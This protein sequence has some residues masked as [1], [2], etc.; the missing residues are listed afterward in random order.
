MARAGRGTGVAQAEPVDAVGRGVEGE[1]RVLVISPAAV[2][3]LVGEGED[4]HPVRRE[5]AARRVDFDLVREATVGLVRR[6]GAEVADPLAL[7]ADE[8]AVVVRP[9]REGRDAHQL[10]LHEQVVVDAEFVPRFEP[11]AGVVRVVVAEGRV[12]L[13]RAAEGRAGHRLAVGV[14]QFEDRV[15]R[16]PEPR[17][18]HLGHEPLALFRPERHDVRGPRR[19]QLAIGR[20]RHRRQCRRGVGERRTRELADDDRRGTDGVAG[21]PLDRHGVPA[22]DGGVGLHGDRL[23]GERPEVDAADGHAGRDAARDAEREDFG[24]HRDR[25][26]VQAVRQPGVAAELAV[27]DADGVAA[28][29]EEFEAEQVAFA[30]DQHA[31]GGVGQRQHGRERGRVGGRHELHAEFVPGRP[32]EAVSV[33]VAGPVEAAGDRRGQ[34]N[35][36]A[37]LALGHGGEAVHGELGRAPGRQGRVADRRGR[38]DGEFGRAADRAVVGRRRQ[39]QCQAVVGGRGGQ[40]V[41]AGAGEGDRRR[42]APAGGVRGDGGHGRRLR[43]GHLAGR[44]VDPQDGS[45]EEAQ[46]ELR[47]VGRQRG[48]RDCVGLRGED[49]DLA[50][51]RGGP[52]LQRPVFADR[53]QHRPL[54]PDEDARHRRLVREHRRRQLAALGGHGP[55]AQAAV[56][57]GGVE[58]LA[59]RLPGDRVNP[60]G[61]VGQGVQPLIR[62]RIPEL[63]GAVGPGAGEQ[64]AVGAVSERVHGVRVVG[65]RR[66]RLARGGQRHGPEFDEPVVPGRGQ[67]LAVR[68]EVDRVNRVL[69]GG[70]RHRVGVVR[71][72]V[73]AQ[74][75]GLAGCPAGHGERPARGERQ[76]RHPA[77][78]PGERAGRVAGGGVGQRHPVAG[79]GGEQFAVGP[80]REG[81]DRRG[82]GR[83][84]RES[85]GEQEDAE[86]GGGPRGEG[87]VLILRSGRR[88]GYRQALPECSARTRLRG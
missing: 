52:R 15:Q 10:A 53:V 32:G 27:A 62:R 82:G 21:G 50:Q 3:V 81:G 48:G 20:E 51:G 77:V 36:L 65:Q 25:A 66:R 44:G 83:H 87:V 30:L 2:V 26:E 34:G 67:G 85:G 35:R 59:V 79:A 75:A 73:N 88:R 86:H 39:L 54:R 12:R 47:S 16:R 56:H 43:L 37:G 42:R 78:L 4:R 17:G 60:V 11:N 69:V 38:G 28:G 23:R 14:E 18:L 8:L 63:D 1:A 22:A 70:Q 64:L 31:A 80:V 46:R 24:N 9:L 45:S 61:R 5:G 74:H 13:G 72:G 71:G 76:A 40:R 19:G 29:R 55:G 33:G 57:A 6:R 84:G 41:E 58:G 49:F 7:D 68:A